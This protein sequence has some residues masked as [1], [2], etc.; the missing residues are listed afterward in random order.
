M[1]GKGD[2]QRP[3]NK[4]SFDANFDAIFRKKDKVNNKQKVK[5]NEKPKTV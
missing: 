2:K 5:K 4:A 1:N 3:T